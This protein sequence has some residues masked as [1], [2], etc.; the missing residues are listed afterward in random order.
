MGRAFDARTLRAALR[1]RYPWLDREELGPRAVE[2]GECDRCG[3]EARLVAMCGPGIHRY[4]GRRCA[5]RLGPRAWCDGHQADAR[6][7]LAWLEQLPEEADDVA[8]LWWV[9]T[10]EIRLDPALVARSPALAEVVA[11]VLDDDA[12]P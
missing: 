7:A 3:H 6:Q 1:S 8:R 10:G 4:L 2:A 5:V 9:A 12:G 11:G